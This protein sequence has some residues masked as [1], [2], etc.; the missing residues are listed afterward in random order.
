M[1]IIKL[2]TLSRVKQALFVNKMFPRKFGFTL[3]SCTNH[4]ENWM[5]RRQCALT[6][7]DEST[8]SNID[9]VIVV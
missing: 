3:H 2:K 8:V 7:D 5:R 4:S 9:E 6:I 1:H